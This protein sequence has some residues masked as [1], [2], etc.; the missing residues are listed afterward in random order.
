MTPKLETA[1]KLLCADLIRHFTTFT[2]CA[3]VRLGPMSEQ[4]SKYSDRTSKAGM[5]VRCKSDTASQR[6]DA[7]EVTRIKRLLNNELDT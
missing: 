1:A 7:S 3:A 2:S 6:S 5:Q 4:R